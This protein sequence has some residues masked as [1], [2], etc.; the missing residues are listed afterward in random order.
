ME[1]CI[2]HMG[3]VPAQIS[4]NTALSSEDEEEGKEEVKDEIK[5]DGEILNEDVK[6]EFDIKPSVEVPLE[7]MDTEFGVEEEIVVTNE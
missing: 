2:Y 3:M 1:P 5:D 6:L 4:Y 7:L